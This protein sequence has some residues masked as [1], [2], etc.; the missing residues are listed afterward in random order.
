MMGELEATIRELQSRV[1]SLEHAARA[2]VEA[3]KRIASA[4]TALDEQYKVHTLL[5][6]VDILAATL[7][8]ENAIK[9]KSITKKKHP[10]SGTWKGEK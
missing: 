1:E 2:V 7:N 5:R 6:I 3:R 8:N 4:E 10:F 9:D